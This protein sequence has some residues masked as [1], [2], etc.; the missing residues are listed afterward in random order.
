MGRYVLNRR[1]SLVQITEGW[2]LEPSVVRVSE[3]EGKIVTP[4][5]T[6]FTSEQVDK[7]KA[8]PNTL[9]L[10]KSQYLAWGEEVSDDES[11]TEEAQAG[12]KKGKKPV[13]PVAS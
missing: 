1:E 9:L 3:V 12:G 4:S 13:E 5:R 2:M 11:V 10:F 8:D 7:I 6:K